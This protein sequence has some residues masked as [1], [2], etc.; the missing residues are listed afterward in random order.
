[1]LVVKFISQ[2]QRNCTWEIPKE[3]EKRLS[4]Q[5]G[6]LTVPA[7]DPSLVP[8]THIKWKFAT[9]C[10]SSSRTFGLLFW[11][12]RRVSVHAHTHTLKSLK[13]IQAPIFSLPHPHPLLRFTALNGCHRRTCSEKLDALQSIFHPLWLPAFSPPR[14]CHRSTKPSVQKTNNLAR[15][16]IPQ[17][18]SNLLEAVKQFCGGGSQ[19]LGP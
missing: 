1:M 10:N 19:A 11:P 17:R 2:H 16:D 6:L 5:L 8:S 7:E 9:T 12:P 14:S 15:T 18:D 3:L 13:N 4:G